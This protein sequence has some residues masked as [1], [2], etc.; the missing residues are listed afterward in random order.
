MV[1]ATLK[2]M[3]PCAVIA[4][5]GCGTVSSARTSEAPPALIS[6]ESVQQPAAPGDRGTSD[7]S[8]PPIDSAGA[9]AQPSDALSPPVVDTAPEAASEPA[10]TEDPPIQWTA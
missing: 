10:K 3:F 9:V 8:G 4:S 2:L 1:E 7:A 5:I 6:S